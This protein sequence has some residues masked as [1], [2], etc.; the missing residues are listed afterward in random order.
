M[1]FFHSHPIGIPSINPIPCV[2]Y[3]N[4]GKRRRWETIEARL[5][6]AGRLIDLHAHALDKDARERTKN[7]AS[8]LFR[9]SARLIVRLAA[10]NTEGAVNLARNVKLRSPIPVSYHP[11]SL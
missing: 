1:R 9:R 4:G 3:E 11:P 2:K 5:T 7:G 8:T 10:G 6:K